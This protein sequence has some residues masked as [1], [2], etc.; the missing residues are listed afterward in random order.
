MMTESMNESSTSLDT[1]TAFGSIIKRHMRLSPIAKNSPQ[2]RSPMM[3]IPGLSRM[4]PLN[5]QA[6][7]ESLLSKTYNKFNHTDRISNNNNNMKYNRTTF[8]FGAN[9]EESEIHS[10]LDSQ[11]LG[12]VKKKSLW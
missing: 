1:T 6:N 10:H 5:I 7:N 8:N 12:G 9:N 3:M 2:I 11:P 4:S